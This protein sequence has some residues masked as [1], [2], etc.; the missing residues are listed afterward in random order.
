M[1]KVRN[2]ITLFLGTLFS[3]GAG[4]LR[5]ILFS[6]WFGTGE[7]AAAFRIAQ[8]AYL[9]PVQALVG[10]TLSAGL[11]PFYKKLQEDNS[12]KRQILI[13]CATLYS[14][15]LSIVIT[16]ILYLFSE[17]ISSFIA[18]NSGSGLLILA[19]QFLK[20]LALSV[21][22][23]ILGGTL[24]FIET[25]YGYFTGIAIRPLLLNIFSIL[26]VMLAVYFKYDYWLVILILI[27][28]IVFLIIT[29]IKIRN[30]DVFFPKTKIKINAVKEVF[31][32]FFKNIFPLLGL[33]LIVQI[34]VLCERIVSSNIGDAVI[35]AVDYARFLCD[36]T[37]QLIAVPLGIITMANFGGSINEKFNEYIKSSF[38]I[39]LL[40]SVPI[41]LF[42]FQNS[43]EIIRIVFHRGAFG[44][45][46]V[47]ITSKAFQWMGLALI[48]TITAYFLIKVLNSMMLNKIAFLFTFLAVLVS[49]FINFVFWKSIGIEVIGLAVIGYSLTLFFLCVIYLKIYNEF[50]IIS[51]S[52]SPFLFGQL[53]LN[54]YILIFF[55]RYYYLGY[56]FL[57][58][59]LMFYW[60]IAVLM[61][62][63]TRKIFKPI[64][65]K[66][67]GKFLF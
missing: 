46:S 10:D 34:N 54:K 47:L 62:P 29:I 23:Y 42:F 55:D 63:Y 13:L 22:F 26:G 32:S 4:F 65:S 39:L 48:F 9:L 21:P 28:H 5:E 57:V 27:S 37:V 12:N 51:L 18:P 36:T 20:I 38:T 58:L 8:T 35:P 66:L 7:T 43:T 45:E 53:L 16:S 40:V 44:E 24:S 14:I 56:L 2:Y 50:L 59:I 67:I 33:P 60:L 64:F 49:I 31:T 15:C 6:A 19:S 17:S 25:A 11:L 30:I 1:S 41:G 3:K 61:I 52:I